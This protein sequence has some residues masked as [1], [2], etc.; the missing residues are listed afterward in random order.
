V[1]HLA[2]E[3]EAPRVGLALWRFAS[4]TV[5]ACAETDNPMVVAVP[6]L[7]FAWDFARK[8]HWTTAVLAV[9]IL[10][11]IIAYCLLWLARLGVDL[12]ND[13]ITYRTLRRTRRLA[14]ADLRPP[15]IEVGEDRSPHTLP[16][17]RRLQRPMVR[18]VLTPHKHPLKH[19]IDVNLMQHDPVAMRA[20]ILHLGVKDA[21]D[22]AGQ[23][24][25]TLSADP[26]SC[27]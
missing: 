2:S 8:S 12:T 13:A 6:T 26:V 25:E 14:L 17:G 7:G 27:R 19:R 23:S 21:D 5:N 24:S 22:G 3:R 1:H 4:P 16:G 18:L 9:G 10:G 11:A 15:V 20:L